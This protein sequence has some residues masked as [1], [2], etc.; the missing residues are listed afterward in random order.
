MIEAK[1]VEDRASASASLVLA[2][3]PEDEDGDEDEAAAASISA[4]LQA[5]GA[6]GVLLVSKGDSLACVR[7]VKTRA[8]TIPGAAPLHPALGLPAHAHR[9]PRART[10]CAVSRRQPQPAQRPLLAR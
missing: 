1:L 10:L 3:M 5:A 2:P 6:V 7:T 4:E 8:V 9:H